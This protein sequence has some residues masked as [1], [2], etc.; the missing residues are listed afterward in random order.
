MRIIVTS[1]EVALTHNPDIKGTNC[2][3]PC[4]LLVMPPFESWTSSGRVE[5]QPSS[6]ANTT[7]NRN[8]RTGRLADR[9]FLCMVLRG[10][11]LHP[12]C[13][14][15]RPNRQH[16]R[17]ASSETRCLYPRPL[18]HDLWDGEALAVCVVWPCR[19]RITCPHHASRRGCDVSNE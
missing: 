12:H 10:T 11:M 1:V 14:S 4:P 2:V 16:R 6:T 19:R 3:A 9:S 17:S 13:F 7:N 18:L 15:T 8:D 5:E